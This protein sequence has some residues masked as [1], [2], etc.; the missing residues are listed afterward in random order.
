MVTKNIKKILLNKD[1]NKFVVDTEDIVRSVNGVNAD[2]NGNVSITSVAFATSATNATN[3]DNATNLGGYPASDYVRSV[4]G[5]NTDAS[6]N[7]QLGNLVKSVNGV[8]ASEN[9]NVTIPLPFVKT[10]NSTAPDSNGNV[11][12][13][14]SS[15]SGGVGFPDLSAGVTISNFNGRYDRDTTR[16]YTLPSSGWVIGELVIPNSPTGARD[17]VYLNT[18]PLSNS[19]FIETKHLYNFYIALKSGTQIKMQIT[20]P[21]HGN[22]DVSSSLRLYPFLS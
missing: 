2:E 21:T 4:N 20:N 12:L 18:S 1:G 19:V 8:N 6:G 7:I 13:D 22:I 15:S 3:A 5:V 11:V 17:A 14:L 10:V 16:T 9:G